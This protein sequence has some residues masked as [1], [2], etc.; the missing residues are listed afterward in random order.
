[1]P[2]SR[3]LKQKRLFQYQTLTQTQIQQQP[4]PK[5]RLKLSLAGEVG[6]KLTES[7][8]S[9]ILCV[10][11]RSSK[12]HLRSPVRRA[13]DAIHMHRLN[14]LAPPS[15]ARPSISYQITAADEKNCSGTS[16]LCCPY[17]FPPKLNKQLNRRLLVYA[18]I[19]RWSRPQQPQ[20]TKCEN[21]S[22]W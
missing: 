8:C 10:P 6:G 9:F 22:I 4:W 17:K 11:Y 20:Q 5:Q 18:E 12:C 7:K 14:C 3:W 19:L 13:D 16:V 15:L 2:R 1:M 21:I